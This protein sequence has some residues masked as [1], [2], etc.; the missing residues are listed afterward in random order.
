MTAILKGDCDAPAMP[1]SG[2][3]AQ[4]AAVIPAPA[5]KLRLETPSMFLLVP[6]DSSGVELHYFIILDVGHSI[7]VVNGQK[8]IFIDKIRRQVHRQTSEQEFYRCLQRAAASDTVHGPLAAAQ[9]AC[10]LTEATCCRAAV[11]GG[12][13]GKLWR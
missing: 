12:R 6:D 13:V 7:Q 10:D 3:V 5:R 8:T 1:K 4:N 2:R 9:C 11:I